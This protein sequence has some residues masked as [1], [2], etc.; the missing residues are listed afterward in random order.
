[1]STIEEMGNAY[2]PPK[3]QTHWYMLLPTAAVGA[4]GEKEAV[5]GMEDVMMGEPEA[6]TG[7]IVTPAGEAAPAV[8]STDDKENTPEENLSSS[9]TNNIV[10]FIDIL[11]RV[12][13]AD[14][15]WCC[16]QQ[17]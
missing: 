7:A 6:E 15:S 16:T 2:V 14:S 9:P 8:A 12:S 11:A 3:D 13:M 17:G 1:M 5:G 10:T 4:E